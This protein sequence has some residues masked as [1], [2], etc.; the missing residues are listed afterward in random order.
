M[1]ILK[2]YSILQNKLFLILLFVVNI[3]ADTIVEKGNKEFLNVNY[4]NIHT[5]MQQVL[6]MD[7]REL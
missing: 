7:L 6:V 1:V 4:L 3:F 5:L 2:N